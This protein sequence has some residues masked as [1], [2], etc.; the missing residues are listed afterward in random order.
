MPSTPHAF[1][2][3]QL[4]FGPGRLYWDTGSGGENLD[5]GETDSIVITLAVAKIELKTSQEGDRPA[6][7]AVS[8]QTY[9]ARAGLARA[10]A[11]RLAKIVQGFKIVTNSAGEITR[12]YGSKV[13]GQ[14][15]SDIWKQLTFKEYEDGKITTNP[16]RIVNFPNAAPMTESTELTYDAT[17]QRFYGVVFETYESAD[18]LDP[19]GNPTYWFTDEVV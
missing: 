1:G 3:A 11:E 9:Q 17:T 19:D 5:L 18:H 15:D 14:R 7:R 8:G 2:D 16:L 13:V 10:T 4:S 12:I 6:D